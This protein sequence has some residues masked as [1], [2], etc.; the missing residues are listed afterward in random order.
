[1]SEVDQGRGVLA[2]ILSALAVVAVA[3][4]LA[5]FG[6]QQEKGQK[7]G[8]SE[9]LESY[10]N[11]IGMVF[12]KLPEGR[13]TMGDNAPGRGPQREVR[14]GS[15]YMSVHEVTQAQW[16]AVM[17]HNPSEHKDPQRPV[18]QV[19][20]LAAQAFLE[21]LNRLEGTNRYRLPTE[22]EWEYAARAGSEQRFSFGDEPA[23]LRQH[24]WVELK[25]GSRPVGLKMP[26][27]W[28]LYDMYG[29]VWEWVQ[30]CWH[31]DYSD[32]PSDA[33]LRSGGDCR[34]RVLRGGGWNSRTEDLGSS[35]RGSYLAH[36]EDMNNGFRV[37]LAR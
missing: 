26:N 14:V 34:Y 7:A 24:G 8:D 36:G 33:R 37:V 10:T 23:R 35:V 22:A 16:A 25:N 13:F 30:E 19:T 28:G 4:G 27:A 9:A 6:S 11:T 5:W 31:E 15:I 17:G 21:E 3:G 29:N 2:L 32:A 1:M 12:V 20:W 18:D